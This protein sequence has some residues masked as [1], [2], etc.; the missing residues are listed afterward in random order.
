M[1]KYVNYHGVTS[2]EVSNIQTTISSTSGEPFYSR[3]LIITMDDGSQE[4]F[5]LFCTNG[6]SM[7]VVDEE[8]AA[9]NAEL[10]LLKA[11]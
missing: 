5:G 4:E 11:A 3:K 6:Y 7:L 2:I 9:M 10:P 8:L 1:S